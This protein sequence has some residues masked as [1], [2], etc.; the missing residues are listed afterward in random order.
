MTIESN[1]SALARPL[2]GVIPPMV[3]PLLDRDRLDVAGLERLIPQ[4][5][6]QPPLT[7][8]TRQQLTAWRVWEGEARVRS[9]PA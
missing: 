4:P 6:P 3:T 9:G 2:R 1:S 5:T 8:R 7:G